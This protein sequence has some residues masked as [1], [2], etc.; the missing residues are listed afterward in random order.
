MVDVRKFV[1]YSARSAK[2]EAKR[3]LRWR[4]PEPWR[5]S[6]RE[7]RSPSRPGRGRQRLGRLAAI[8]DVGARPSHPQ[9]RERSLG[10]PVVTTEGGRGDPLNQPRLTISGPVVPHADPGSRERYLRRNPKAKLYA[11]FAGLSVRRMRIEAIHFNGGFGRADAMPVAE[12]LAPSR[13]TYL[14][15]VGAQAGL[16]E[17]VDQL[18]GGQDRWPCDRPVVRPTSLAGRRAGREGLDLVAAVRGAR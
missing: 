13:A 1:R 12:L 9:P 6:T 4:G 3:L 8:P 16:L 11:R 7:R 5:R 10:V 15:T 18:G 14:R 2:S 17:Q